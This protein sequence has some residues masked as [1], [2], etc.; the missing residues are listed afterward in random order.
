MSLIRKQLPA[1]IPLLGFA[2]APFTLASYAVEGSGSK[3]YRHIKSW[4][5]GDAGAW[6]ALMTAISDSVAD[7]LIAQLH[8]GCQ[9]VQLFDSW[10]GCLSPAD[11]RA[12]VLPYSKRVIDKVNPHGPVIHF[13]TGNPALIPAQ[14]EAG[15]DVLGLDWRTDLAR[16]VGHDRRPLGRARQ[17][18][19]D[20]P[21]RRLGTGPPTSHRHPRQRQGPTGSH[22]QPRPRRHPPNRRPKRQR[23]GETCA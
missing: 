7:Y 1:D 19:P 10:A 21:L 11:Y 4:L 5:W 2:G 20:P 12:K 3:D 14:T 18:G 23:L 8:A 22:L 13:L 17:H 9:A 6:D 15:G 16:N